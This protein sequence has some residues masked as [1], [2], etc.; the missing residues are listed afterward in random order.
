MGSS[1]VHCSGLFR[2]QQGAAAWEGEDGLERGGGGGFRVYNNH[3]TTIAQFFS[4]GLLLSYS[5]CGLFIY[6]S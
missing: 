1:R 5:V 6:G 2:Y 4:G 3:T